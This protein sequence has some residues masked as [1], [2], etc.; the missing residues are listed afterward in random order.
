QRLDA[1]IFI[2]GHMPQE[3]GYAVVGRMIILASEHAHGTFLPI[4]LR[5]RYTVDELAGAIRKFV[6]I[7]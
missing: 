2:T 1:D 3:M 7:E 4:D 6:E 5:R